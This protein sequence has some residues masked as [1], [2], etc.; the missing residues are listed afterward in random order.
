MAR[1]RSDQ[2]TL[3]GRK[4]RADAL[5]RA[6]PRFDPMPPKERG[7]EGVTQVTMGR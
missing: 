2:R 3:A 6:H 4:A 7:P 5:L 1:S